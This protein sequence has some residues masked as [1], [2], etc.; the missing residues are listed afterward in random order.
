[1]RC[2]PF[3]WRL[4]TAAAVLNLCTT[5]CRAISAPHRCR[6]ISVPHSRRAISVPHGLA[7]RHPRTIL[8]SK[9]AVPG[10]QPAIVRNQAAILGGHAAILGG[11]RTTWRW[12]AEPSQRACRLQRARP[13]FALRPPPRQPR[14]W[15]S[16]PPPEP[17]PRFRIW[18]SSGWTRCRLRARPQPARIKCVSARC[19]HALYQKRGVSSLIAPRILFDQALSYAMCGTEIALSYAICSTAIPVLQG[20]WGTEI[21]L[22][23][24]ICGTELAKVD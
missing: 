12:R 5:R 20:M 18:R 6:A 7:K 3:S 19:Q 13:P 4:S 8:R 24:A 11:A 23:Y 14:P 15:G 16:H 1:M 21:V 10:S 2:H 22:S 17:G 9:T